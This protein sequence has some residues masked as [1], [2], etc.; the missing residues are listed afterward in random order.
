MVRAGSGVF[1]EDG[2]GA[3]WLK[4]PQEGNSMA[5]RLGYT[6]SAR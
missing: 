3:V 4:D 6:G 1:A 5:E 2:P